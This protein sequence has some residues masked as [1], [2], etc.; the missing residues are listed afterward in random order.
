ML[1]RCRGAVQCRCLQEERSVGY[2][3][4]QGKRRVV[5]G[6]GES[7][8]TSIRGLF[9]VC[10]PW[11]PLGPCILNHLTGP[12]YANH[13][14]IRASNRY[15]LAH[16]G[17]DCFCVTSGYRMQRSPYRPSR[18]DLWV[19]SAVS[20]RPE[21]AGDES[22]HGLK[23]IR[24]RFIPKRAPITRAC[25]LPACERHWWMTTVHI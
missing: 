19:L 16:A 13:C 12:I 15:I 4:L 20:T 11:R 2:K 21:F 10:K 8:I 18:D 9:C 22:F 25:S 6:R 14:S 1:K 7:V 17:L 3:I 23:I 5:L 24:L